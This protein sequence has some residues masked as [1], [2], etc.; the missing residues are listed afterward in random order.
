MTARYEHHIAPTGSGSGP[1]PPPEDVP[2]RDAHVIVVAQDEWLLD[3][4]D[5]GDP[6]MPANNLNLEAAVG[7]QLSITCD[8]L[9]PGDGSELQLALAAALAG[10]VPIDI[11]LRPCNLQLTSATVGAA[12]LS[13]P[14][15]CRLI[16]A[17]QNISVVSGT[18]G[19]GTST[20][21]VVTLGANAQVEDLA[22]LSPAPT[23]KPAITTRAVIESG[24]GG[25]VLRCVVAATRS[26]QIQR[27][28]IVGFSCAAPSGLELIQDTLFYID[29]V[30]DQP[31]GGES[32]AIEFGT[33]TSA[34]ALIDSDPE[35]N[36][37][38]IRGVTPGLG[39]CPIAVRFTNVEGG[40][41]S[42]V[43]CAGSL[44]PSQS[45]A[46]AWFW[47]AVS[48][49]P[50]T[51]A[52]RGPRWQQCRLTARNTETSSQLG[53]VVY[54]TGAVNLAEGVNRSSFT[55]CSVRF[56]RN[57]NPNPGISK[58]AFLVVNEATDGSGIFDTSFTS[59][60]ALNHNR[61]FVFN[62]S[63]Q[64]GV[65]RSVVATGCQARNAVEGNSPAPRGA[66]LRGL[67][68]QGALLANVGLVNCDFSGAEGASGAGVEIQDA[69][70]I[71]TIVVAN[72]LT[73]GGAGVA[74]ID[75]GTGS[76]VATNI[77]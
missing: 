35:V 31:G 72:N 47:S 9:D 54:V 19:T 43:E 67:G 57:Q 32:I 74:V 49:T 30:Y 69:S 63:G 52:L 55:D 16:G 40:F 34:A 75:A 60:K 10:G 36:G 62:A 38:R 25:K 61:G 50:V 51:R 4:S 70:V 22:I 2:I 73:P 71:N 1:A 44:R 17:G 18:D 20:Q 15:G 46:F 24:S 11:R 6:P 76:Q 39:A 59:C 29:P 53:F 65:I 13:V 5:V 66:L 26:T 12:G 77:I 14:A 23:V 56:E 37:V 48:V 58:I 21:T 45:G 68:Q 3:L 27:S 28:Q 42:N 41:V 8:Y 33:P 7:D 64:T